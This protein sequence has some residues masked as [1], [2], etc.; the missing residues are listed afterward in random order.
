MIMNELRA[1]MIT[2]DNLEQAAAAMFE[3]RVQASQDDDPA[4]RHPMMYG[5]HKWASL[6]DSEKTYYKDMLK[7]AFD[8]VGVKVET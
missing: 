7:V 3:F 6:P 5:G 2:Q 8:V 4:Y 1:N